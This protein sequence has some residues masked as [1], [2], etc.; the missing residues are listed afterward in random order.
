MKGSGAHMLKGSAWMISLRWAMRLIG[1]VST[2][3]LARILTP[4]DFGIVAVAMILVGL[5]EML[6]MTGQAAAIVRLEAPTREH[7]DSAWTVSVA[8]GLFIAAAILIAAPFTEHY[9]HEPRAILVMQCLAVRA[10]LGGLENIG[11]VDFSRELRFDRFFVYNVV[12]KV[13]QFVLTV[14]LAVVLRNYWA[15]VVGILAG[16]A[17]RTA[18]SYWMSP[19]RPRLSFAR[20]GEIWSFSIWTFARSVAGYLQ[21]QVD[22]I[23][24]GGIAGAAMMGR[25][26]VAKDIATSPTQE[27][28]TPMI[29]A[30]F[31]VMSKCRNDPEELHRLYLRMLG[32]SAIIC[33]STGVGVAMVAPDMV[34]VILGPKWIDATP[35]VV[36]MALNAAT[37]TLLSGTGT[38]LDVLG[39]PGLSAQIQW[40]RFALF[41][42]VIFA[43]AWSFRSVMAVVETRVIVSAL[44]IPS[45]IFAVRNASGVSARDHLS[46]MWRPALAAAGMAL[47]IW[48]VHG[49]NPFGPLIRLSVDVLV[50]ALS[51]TGLLLGLWEL[52]GRPRAAEGDILTLLEH[53][54]IKVL[55]FSAQPAN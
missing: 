39:K 45:V 35:L 2:I 49:I 36:F 23:A 51:F 19:F 17:S 38:L 25:Y 54:R 48:G 31:P 14:T 20:T 55:R 4:Q 21:T 27:I 32:W 33:L 53:A 47:A 22:N 44:F 40:T 3:I 13:L 52:S 12:T 43:V 30:L 18:L 50:G 24:I 10:V 8:I 1:V 7:Y 46:A 34:R 29:A 5:F 16:Q 11:T 28:M 6:N 15:L 41:T 42:A 26:T 37:A 9:F